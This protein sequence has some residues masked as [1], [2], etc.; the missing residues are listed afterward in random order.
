L[1]IQLT[2]R[3]P[4]T[5][6]QLTQ[7]QR[8][9]VVDELTSNLVVPVIGHDN[10]AAYKTSFNDSQTD[11]AARISFKVRTFISV[12]ISVLYPLLKFLIRFI[13]PFPY[14]FHRMVVQE[15]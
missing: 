6:S 13:Y 9:A 7:S 15:V 2:G 14:L 5:T 8:A 10:L 3:K 4:I 1:R 11:K 12:I